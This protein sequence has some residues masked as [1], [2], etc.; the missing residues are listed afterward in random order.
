ML[1]SKIAVKSDEV[2]D[3]TSNHASLHRELPFVCW[4]G[5]LAN[6]FI[7]LTGGAFLTGVALYLGAGD[8]EIG[9]LGAI[10]FFAQ[11]V[12]LLAAYVIDRWG[13][14]K[15]IT[16]LASLLARQLWWLL[17]P[18]LFISQS[19]RLTAFLVLVI[20]S[21]IAIMIATP[22]WLSW[23]ADLFPARIRGRVFGSRSAAVATATVSATVLGGL[24]LDHFH[25]L[26][27]EATGFATLI[28]MACLFALAAVLLQRVVSDR[29]MPGRDSRLSL[30]ALLKPLR[31][32]EFRRLLRVFFMWNLAIGI[33]AAFF[34]P[35]MLTN[36]KMNFTQISL[37]SSAVSLAAVGLNKP[38]G[39][40]IDRFGAKPVIV[41]CAFGI[42]VIPI[43]W[44][45][46][47]PDFRWILGIEAIYT[48]ALWTG[49][50]LAA[51]N[52]P[53]AHSPNRSR[54]TYLAVFSVA[55][56]IAFFLASLSGGILAEW[57]APIHWH[58]GS[59]T[60]VNYH[61]LFVI[62]A[63]LR[64]AAAFMFVGF[65]EPREQGVPVMIQFMGYAFLK[66]IT[67]GR[68]LLPFGL[69]QQIENGLGIHHINKAV[70]Q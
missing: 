2:A 37:Y 12:Q 65:H 42:S 8:F 38:W 17:I 64:L 29:P 40:V 24:I 28:A 63:F 20:L 66:R 31:N 26:H 58:V 52:M 30:A 53:L 51:F 16:L 18:L 35:H 49:F 7:V 61:I 25:R 68:P 56:G 45:F 15:Q 70:D 48:G 11:T 54:T 50:N 55:T 14:R 3:A 46:P 36:L 43:V 22:G 41:F 34:A 67:V 9:L 44:L 69:K 59:Q 60:V 57:L 27:H 33:S 62:S 13:R 39:K 47:R 21:S 19:W 4:E 6:V 5:A 10:P 32:V 1:S 23:M